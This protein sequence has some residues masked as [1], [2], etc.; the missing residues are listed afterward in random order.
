MGTRIEK[1]LGTRL[2][3]RISWVHISAGPLPTWWDPGRAV[4]GSH[5]YKGDDC[6]HLMAFRKKTQG[7]CLAA[8]PG[9]NRYGYRS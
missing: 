3:S 6:P 1:R 5:L 8:S 4:V 9:Q 7:G 2:W